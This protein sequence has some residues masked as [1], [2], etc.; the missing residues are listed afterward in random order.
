MARLALQQ[1]IGDDTD[2]VGSARQGGIGHQTHKADATAAIDQR[3]AFA[4]QQATQLYGGFA[5]GRVGAEAGA[6]KN[7]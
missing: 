2:D 6:A 3:Y 7:T 1:E 4:G 5:R